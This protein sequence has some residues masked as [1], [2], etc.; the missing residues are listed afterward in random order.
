[1]PLVKIGGVGTVGVNRDLS[2]AELPPNAWTD[3]LNIRFLDGYANQF[4]GHAQVY[5]TP[6][7]TP[8]HLVP[9][10]IG[11]AR[12]WIYT[13]AAKT[14]AVTVTGGVGVETDI[15]H[16]TPRAG[17]VNQ[18]TSTVLSGIPILNTGDTTTVP[19]TWDLNTANKFV[20]LANWPANTYCKSLKAFKNSLIALNVSKSGTQYPYMVKWSHPA[21][22]GSVPSSWDQTDATKDAGELDLAEGGDYIQ[23]GLQLR[24]SFIIYKEA[25]VWRMDYT[26]G[27]FVYRFSKVLGISGALNRNCITEIDGQHLVLTGSDVMVHDG[28][29]ASSVLDKFTRRWLFQNI[30]TTYIGRCFVARN[31]FFNEVWVCFP[32][33]GATSCDRAMI[34]NYRDNTVSFRSLPNVN[35]LSF[36]PVDNG[37]NDSWSS[38]SAPWDS[39]LTLWNGPDY[40]PSTTRLL[41][42]SADTKLF[43]MDAS[44]SFDGALPSAYIERRGLSF[45]NI[46]KLKLVKGIRAQITGNTGDTVLIYVGSSD[47]PYEDPTYGDAM[48]FTIGSTTQVDC[49]VTGRYIAVKFATGTAFNWRLDSYSIMVDTAGAY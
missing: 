21:D 33:L 26:G 49:F 45:D 5:G 43:L 16:V 9:V 41:A 38:D 37:L 1:M 3:A 35:H 10:N 18:W 7:A 11:G 28:Q 2:S 15:T 29:S 22:P 13:T 36:G 47:D 24:D 17:V 46:E 48:T 40:V 34:W 6:S 20:N 31:P 42:A 25:S 4:Y 32:S 27:P 30:D 23:D 19:M 12:Y 44:A 39:D 8:Q 14:Y